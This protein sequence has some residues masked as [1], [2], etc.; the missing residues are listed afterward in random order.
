MAH[1]IEQFGE[2]RAAVAL[3]RTPGW[4]RLGTVTKEAMTADEAL[5]LAYLANWG[6]HTIPLVGLVDGDDCAEC[7]HKLGD[8][9]DDYCAI[10]DHD[11]EDDTRIVVAE[12]TSIPIPV[13]DFFAT[14][15]NHPIS[16]KPESLGV[17]GT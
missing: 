2:G 9:H 4:H 12:D 10:G 6:V 3:A 17:V 8:K 5:N 7:H 11:G 15:R 1:E 13:T 14:V 16:G